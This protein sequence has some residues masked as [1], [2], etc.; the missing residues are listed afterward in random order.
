M[1]QYKSFTLDN[2]L[3]VIV[4]EDQSFPNVILDIIYNVG[5]RDEDPEKTG[6]AH[7]FEHLMFGGSKHISEFDTP[8]QRVGGSCN[9]FTSPDVTNYYINLPA[10]NI[11]TAFWLE[12][13]RMKSLSFDPKVLEVQ[14]KVVIEEFKQRYLNQPYGDVWMKLRELAYKV[15][16]YRW[17]TIGKEI[18]HIEQAVMDDV[19]EFFFK[20][21]RP[22]NAVMIVA[23]NTT[24]EEVK[25]LSEKWFGDI[26]SGEK[27]TRNLPKEP[28]QTE[29][30]LLKVEENVPVDALHK[31]YH[32]CDKLHPDFYATDIL[33]E[34]LG[35]GKSSKLY[36]KLVKEDKIFSSFS[37]YISGSFDNG[38]LTFSGKM[39]E[40]ISLEEG[41][42]A[43]ENALAAVAQE[44]VIDTELQKIKN[45][46][47]FSMA[48]GKQELM[49][50]AMGLAFASVL[51]DTELVNKEEELIQKVSVDQVNRLAKELLR[52]EN[53]STL[54]YA[55]KN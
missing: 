52:N 11:E 53:S 10:Q 27:Y 9:A 7:L 28:V 36:Q 48:Y 51:G 34:I 15:H 55:S 45:Q 42:A 46:A 4:H 24:L 2:G 3:K 37:S 1:I 25:R 49:P 21:Y 26:E 19:K 44:G 54:L 32:M 6:F 22:C 35:R 13:D 5:S 47:E 20:Y 29:A 43:L 18:A 38:L 33:S 39:Q 50:R 40:G 41:N 14:R 23:G 17:P 16:P 31:V 8:L 12:S 30:R